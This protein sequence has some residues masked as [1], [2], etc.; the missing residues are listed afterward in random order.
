MQFPSARCGLSLSNGVFGPF[1]AADFGL[2]RYRWYR[3]RFLDNDYLVRLDAPDRSPGVNSTNDWE[4][5]PNDLQLQVRT[6]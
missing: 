3:P 6:A 2:G 4:E 1:H 5:N